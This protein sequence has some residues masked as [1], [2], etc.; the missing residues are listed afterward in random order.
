MD[1]H[2]IEHPEE[3]AKKINNKIIFFASSKVLK[4]SG[5]FMQH[6]YRQQ[7]RK[8]LSAGQIDDN[9]FTNL[10]LYAE[11]VVAIREDLGIDGPWTRV[12]WADIVR[13][14]ISDLDEYTPSRF[15]RNRKRRTLPYVRFRK[16]RKI[17]GGITSEIE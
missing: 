4:A 10:K 6:L 15:S 8:G 16:H 9:N 1:G 5:D 7:K 11:L 17:V 3:K 2:K 13:P 14:T 12:S